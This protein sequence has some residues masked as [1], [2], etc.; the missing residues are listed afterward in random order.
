[1]GTSPVIIHFET[2]GYS[3]IL[4]YHILNSETIAMMQMQF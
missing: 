3:G 2:W 4:C 1:M